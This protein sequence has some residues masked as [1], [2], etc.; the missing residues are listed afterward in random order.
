MSTSRSDSQSQNASPYR[1]KRSNTVQSMLRSPVLESLAIGSSTELSLW[2]HE[3][4]TTTADVIFNPEYWPG[5]AE[6]DYVKVT[7]VDEDS[8]SSWEKVG[9]LFV[10]KSPPDEARLS[11]TLQV[12]MY[13][14]RNGCGC[15]FHP[16]RYL[17]RSLSPVHSD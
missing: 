6:G 2:V 17:S 16:H 5:I 13:F 15:L 11:N 9:F 14:I 10:V 1:R 7:E 4:K 12:S 8:N 3:P